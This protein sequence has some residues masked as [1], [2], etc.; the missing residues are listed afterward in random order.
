MELQVSLPVVIER[1][2]VMIRVV[3]RDG[4]RHP[5]LASGHGPPFPCVQLQDRLVNIVVERHYQRLQILDDLVH[6]LDHRRDRLMLVQHPLDPEAP[7][8]GPPQRCQQH[9]AD[10]VA[11]RVA[12][13]PLKGLEHEVGGAA[14]C[15]LLG[16]LDPLGEDQACQIDLWIHPRYSPLCHLE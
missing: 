14:I 13:A 11:E 3:D 4:P 2:E 6:V 16:N 10:G 5:D 8:G 15:R 12:I 1:E 9:P 7:H